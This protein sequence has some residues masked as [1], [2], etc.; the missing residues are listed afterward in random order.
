MGGGARRD[1]DDV[2][3]LPV[4][5]REAGPLR[6]AIIG[7]GQIG[8][9]FA[10]QLSQGGHEVT[11][12]ARP[13]SERLAQLRR[14]AAIITSKGDRA[15]VGVT[16]TLDEQAAYDLV[17]VTLLAH[18]V[19][20]ILGALTR[21]CARCVQ[22]MFNI[23]DPERLQ[24]AL[25]SERCTFGMPF[26]QA[27]LD[28]DGRLSKTIGAFGQKTII[29]RR[30]SVDLFNAVGLPASFEPDMP[31]WLR[32]HAPVCVAFEAV[33]VAGERRRGGA[34][35]AEALVLARG[36]QACFALIEALGYDIYPRAKALMFR[37]PA[38]RLA[39]TLWV[40]SRIRSFRELLASGEAECRAL[41]QIMVKTGVENGHPDSVMR[42]EAME[43]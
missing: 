9:T 7:G 25:G 14:D 24:R 1:G 19:D 23:F 3:A 40:M 36:V 22:F 27:R 13:G 6:I 15:S 2:F 42:I 17:V 34:S 26:V 4:N 8:S 32:C 11:V 16:D 10:F 29:G 35:W 39:A 21:S 43:P 18:Q 30:A 38:V 41:V 5:A 12:V 33:S 28:R 31:L 20:A 37:R